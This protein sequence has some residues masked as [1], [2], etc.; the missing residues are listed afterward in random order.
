MGDD[1][2]IRTRRL[3]FLRQGEG[4]NDKKDIASWDRTR[5]PN[6]NKP[7]AVKAETQQV[8]LAAFLQMMAQGRI[9]VIGPIERLFLNSR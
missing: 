9:D 7:A 3:V 8:S 1:F 6:Q 5:F 2:G 4:R